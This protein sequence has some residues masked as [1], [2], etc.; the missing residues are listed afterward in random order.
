HVLREAR[1]SRGAIEFESTETCIVFDNKGKISRIEPLERNEAHRIIEECMLSAN[2][3]AA[4]FLKKHKMPSLY[5]NHEGPPIEKLLNLRQ[6]L[7]ELGL[8]LG[9]ED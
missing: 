3:A 4:R 9:G 1:M 5:R 2:V 7:S 6:F 8:R